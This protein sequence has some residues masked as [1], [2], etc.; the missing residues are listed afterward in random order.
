LEGLG[1]AQLS[2]HYACVTNLSP[3]HLNRYGSMAEYAEA[4][5][6]IMLWQG[7]D[8]VVV[9]NADDAEVAGWAIQAPGSVVWFGERRM[10]RAD[11]GAFVENNALWWSAEPGHEE[12]ICAVD[13]IRLPGRHN[14]LN[15]AAAAA[16]AR[17]FGVDAEH[18]R[19]AIHAFGGVPDRLELVRELD[20]V[21]YINDTTAT[22]PEAAIAALHSFNAPIVLICGGA[23]K[24]LPFEALAG[25][26][27]ERAKAAV[28]LDGTAT[29]KLLRA[30]QTTDTR[31]TTTDSTIPSSIVGPFDDFAQA[32]AT[33][34]SLAEP[35]D[36]VLLSPGCASFG[37]FRNEFHRGEEFRRIVSELSV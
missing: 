4:K 20:G 35:G 23:D 33:A 32:I 15:V 3:D 22:A 8:G 26:I 24:D 30:L 5:K 21:R 36:V 28:V 16:L 14:V 6:Q 9:L 31:G 17:S 10:R 1:E 29:P 37:M 25:A 34:R 12:R 19:A 27:A 13:D 2:P 11:R 18:I 7:A